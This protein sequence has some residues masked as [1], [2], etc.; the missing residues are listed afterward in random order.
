MPLQ[1][2][3]DLWVHPGDIIIADV[4]GVVVTPPSLVDQVVA[5][6]QERAEIDAKMFEGL[7]K[8]EEMGEL[9]RTLRKGS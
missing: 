5:L 9:I 4:D 2:Q 1:F 8:G 7:H 3:G 6:C